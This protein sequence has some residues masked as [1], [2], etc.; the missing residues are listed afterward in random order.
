MNVVHRSIREHGFSLIEV[1]VAFSIMAL[2]LGVLYQALGGSMRAAGEAER[3]VRA[4]LVAESILA[5]YDSVPPGGLD[6][7]GIAD[8]FDWHLR[9]APVPPLD[10][11][12]D[13]WTLQNIE[14]EVSWEDRGAVR[15]FRL[16]T[17][18]PEVDPAIIDINAGGGR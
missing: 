12:P 7:S 8:G 13:A 18:R 17:V 6:V 2:A 9:T 3:H 14:V 15:R 10:E 16:V 4:V 5:Q 1:L 11:H